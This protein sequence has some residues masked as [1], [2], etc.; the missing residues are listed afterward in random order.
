MTPALRTTVALT[1]A[2]VALTASATYLAAAFSPWAA[3]AGLYVAAF[4]AWSATRQY[5]AHRL[6]R[7][8]AVLA[9]RAAR[10]L[11]IDPRVFDTIPCCHLS[12]RAARQT[13]SADCLRQ[14]A[15]ATRGSAATELNAALEEQPAPPP[16]G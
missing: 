14:Y 6:A 9:E 2:A 11:P 8:R 4:L 10:G 3:V 12:G 15:T 7:A 1:L 5:A 13:H 16:L